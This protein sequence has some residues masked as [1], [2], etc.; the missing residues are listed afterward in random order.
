MSRTATVGGATADGVT[1]GISSVGVG[2]CGDACVG[3]C[4]VD[5]V[6]V[7]GCVPDGE[8]DGAGVDGSV[9]DCLGGWESW[10]ERGSL[11]LLLR[12]R[13]A[14]GSNLRTAP[15]WVLG[16]AVAV[17]A[18]VTRMGT[19]A[20]I[21]VPGCAPGCA[22]GAAARI[23]VAVIAPPW[24]SVVGAPSTAPRATPGVPGP[25]ATAWPTA[26]GLAACGPGWNGQVRALFGHLVP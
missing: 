15:V 18:A 22:A 17:G 9:S 7:G 25:A 20:A 2:E 1:T 19:P 23:W 4:V 10:L 11:V 26:E 24:A 13:W 6:A 14:G 3:D 16:A 12:R 5:C 21:A 8:G